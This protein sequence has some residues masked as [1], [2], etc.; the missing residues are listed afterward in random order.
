MLS[1][2]AL[3]TRGSAVTSLLIIQR[4]LVQIQQRLHVFTFAAAGRERQSRSLPQFKKIRR[5][6]SSQR[7]PRTSTL[8]RAVLFVD[9]MKSSFM[10]GSAASQE[11]WLVCHCIMVDM[12]GIILAITIGGK[13]SF[14]RLCCRKVVYIG[15][16]EREREREREQWSVLID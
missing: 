10:V 3:S 1:R 11:L 16:R 6:K 9:L 13:Y 8:S 4:L 7:R 5:S 12:V 15:E 14:Q 2:V